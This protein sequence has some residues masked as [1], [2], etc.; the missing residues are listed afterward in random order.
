MNLMNNAAAIEK[1]K[2]LAKPLIFYS[3]VKIL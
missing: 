1:I 3:Q 2:G